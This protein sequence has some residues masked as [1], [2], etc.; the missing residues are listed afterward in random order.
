MDVFLKIPEESPDYLAA[1]AGVV[2]AL[3]AIMQQTIE[4]GRNRIFIQTNLKHDLPI[5][6]IRKVAGPL[7]EAWAREQFK[8]LADDASNAY[9]L[10][11]VQAGKRLDPFDVILQFKRPRAGGAA[12]PANV[13]VEPAAAEGLQTSGTSSNITSFA[14]L[15]SEYVQDPDSLF[16][17]LSLKHTVYGERDAVTGLTHGVMEVIAC[18]AYDLK[19]ISPPGLSYNPA[20]GTGQ[21]QIREVRYATLVER[22]TWEFLQMLDAKFIRSKGEAAWLALAGKHGWIKPDKMTG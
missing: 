7:V 13:E 2:D 20:L 18:A 17:I 14:W 9:K 11:N 10:L 3:S 12:A 15:R 21:L 16:I 6:N 22:T 1:S 8:A 19:Y 5:E 4:Q